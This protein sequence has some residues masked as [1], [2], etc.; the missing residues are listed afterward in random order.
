M[1]AQILHFG[2]CGG[3]IAVQQSCDA[4]L[5]FIVL[6]RRLLNLKEIRCGENQDWRPNRLLITSGLSVIR[7]STESGSLT[8]PW[9]I[10]L[11]LS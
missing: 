6:K 11:P 3:M 1:G 2:D 10:E 5:G 4:R 9:T 7:Q 8:V